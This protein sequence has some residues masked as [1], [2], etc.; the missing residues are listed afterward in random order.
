MAGYVDAFVIPV[1]K[2]KIDDYKKIARKMGKLWM[3]HGAL[4]YHEAVA[5]DVPFGKETSFPRGVGRKN[6]ETIVLGWARYKSR[7]HRDKVMAKVM[8]DPRMGKEMAGAGDVMDASRMVFGGF[9]EFL[10]L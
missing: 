7:A 10:G 9:S 4:E 3:E 2:N 5:E 1:R 6:N 8:A